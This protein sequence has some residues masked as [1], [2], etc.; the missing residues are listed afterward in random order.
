[1]AKYLLQGTYT[2]AGV[3]GVLKDGGTG[4]RAVVEELVGNLGGSVEAFYFGL[5]DNDVFVIVDLPG[6]TDVAAASMAV[7]ATGAVALKTVVLMTAEE[8]DEASKK[9]VNYRAP[10]T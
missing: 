2:S 1:M 9:T 5:G 6:N 8:V 7:N 4:R 3:A 10:G